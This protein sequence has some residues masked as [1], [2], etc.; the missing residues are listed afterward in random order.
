MSNEFS[1]FVKA[2]IDA[3]PSVRK[4]RSAFVELGSSIEKH[5]EEVHHKQQAIREDSR[6]GSRLTKH[7]FSL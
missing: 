7:R 1:R 4:A 2:V 3:E 6:R 5:S